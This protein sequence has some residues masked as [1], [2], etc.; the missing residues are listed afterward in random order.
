MVGA[1]VFPDEIVR[2][3]RGGR[4]TRKP[5]RPNTRRPLVD[6]RERIAVAPHLG[7]AEPD[8]KWWWPTIAGRPLTRLASSSP[9][10]GAR[11]I[12]LRLELSQRR[13]APTMRRT[14]RQ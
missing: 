4:P 7:G 9:T 1:L 14:T 10:D 2:H 12:F 8:G 11:Q 13:L 6:H 3:H 5:S